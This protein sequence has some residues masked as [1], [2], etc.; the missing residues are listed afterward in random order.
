MNPGRWQHIA[1]TFAELNLGS[2]TFNPDEFIYSSDISEASLLTRKV[3]QASTIIIL[4]GL[5]FISVLFY[6][7]KNLKRVVNEKTLH[8][9]KA[10]RELIVYTKQLKDKEDELH[11]LN[12]EL[13]KRI[14]TRTETINKIN[15][16]LSEE[17]N[18]RKKREVSLQLLSQAIESSDSIVLII[19]KD[20]IISYASKAFMKLTG[21]GNMKLEGQSISILEN[22]LSLPPIS[23]QAL[24]TQDYS[25]NTE[26]LVQSK[27]KFIDADDEVHW[28]KTSISLLKDHH[29]QEA[30]EISHYVITFED[31]TDIKNHHDEL[32][33]MA[34]YDPLT[35][36]ENRVLFQKRL[37]SAIENAKRNMVKTAL[38]F[39]D[40]DNFKIINDSLGHLAG[41]EILKAI[42]GRLG[43]HV[44]QNDSIARISGDEFT[45]LLSDIKNYEDASIVT[46]NIINSFDV[47]VIID[48]QEVFI[49]ASIGISL[50]PEDSLDA[51]ELINNADVAMYQAKQNGR[52]NYQ[53]FSEDMNSEIQYKIKTEEEIKQGIEKE[54]F[55]LVYQPV[56]NLKTQDVFGVEAT[57]HWQHT[58]QSIRMPDDFI[59]IAENAGSIIPLGKWMLQQVVQDIQKLLKE[60]I[61]NINISVNISP[62]QL[63]D[64]YFVSEVR[65]LF[66]E[67]P[68]Y[69]KYLH[70]EVVESCFIDQKP[71]IIGRLKELKEMGINLI[72]DRF[73]AGYASMSYLKQVPAD[74]IKIDQRYLNG[75]PENQINTNFSNAI[76]SMAHELKLSVT[77]DGV[78]NDLQLA[79]L[80]KQGCDYAQG[81]VFVDPMKLHELLEY[82]SS[83]HTSPHKLSQKS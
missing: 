74:A 52:N 80:K 65:A 67:H 71:E 35:G 28:M 23:T 54:E 20:H 41:D 64:R 21:S 25:P 78:N 48:S 6:V 31:I 7:N 10:N 69:I 81:S 4:L 73:G 82:L 8:L 14:I 2:G 76:I 53:F 32:E 42:A 62:R 60:G 59:P 34:L 12:S 3:L 61:K 18:Q 26:G 63:K 57:V 5:A 29:F 19:D 46:Q 77:A 45:V 16:E 47:P 68:N 24:S 75:L 17:I 51:Q 70:F 50:T 22:K 40:I 44:R 30:P 11:K 58:E 55:F 38:L 37:E 43:N 72:I 56:F 66:S 33:R 36:L 49:T 83:P 15:Y 13:E 27:L 9:T 1:D 79:H 39:I